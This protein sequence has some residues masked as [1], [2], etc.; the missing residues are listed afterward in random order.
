MSSF[1][2]A[3]AS[4]LNTTSQATTKEFFTSNTSIL[5]PS[6]KQEKEQSN[7]SAHINQILCQGE[8]GKLLKLHTTYFLCFKETCKGS[9]ES[10]NLH[11]SEEGTM[12]AAFSPD[13]K[14]KLKKNSVKN[15]QRLALLR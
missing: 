3:Q 14:K 12:E 6:S 8:G 13:I 5:R 15:T 1:L 9:T 2:E 4:F 7:S 10:N 11:F